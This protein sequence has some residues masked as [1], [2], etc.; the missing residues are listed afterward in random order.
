MLQIEC[1]KKP[2]TTLI[3]VISVDQ[4]ARISQ[5][6]LN[7][8]VQFTEAL[9]PHRKYIHLIQSGVNSALNGS[10]EYTIYIL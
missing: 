2:S 4:T 1:Q 7:T 5:E 10:S 9:R 8:T 3:K 6:A